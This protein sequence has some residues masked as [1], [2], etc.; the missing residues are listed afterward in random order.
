MSQP[1]LVDPRDTTGLDV[2]GLLNPTHLAHLAGLGPK[3]ALFGGWRMKDEGCDDPDCEDEDCDGDHGVEDTD[4]ETE[5]V[6]GGKTLKVGKLQRIMA[7]EKRQGKKAG[8]TA[9][10]TELGFDS[11]DDAKAFVEKNKQAKPPKKKT[12][13]NDDDEAATAAARERETA[14]EK[15][16]RLAAE[17]ER[18]AD[19]RG[20]LRDAGVS[21]DDLDDVHA[22]LDREVDAEYDED[23]LEEAV[24]ALKERRPSF[25]GQKDEDAERPRPRAKAKIPAGGGP[26]RKTSQGKTG[27]DAGKARAQRRW[28][29]TTTKD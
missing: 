2:T 14:A 18:K 15:R 20:A 10:L 4:P 22:L 16:E 19:L 26:R 23:E 21:R 12:G 28:G 8:Q 17:K 9:L 13:E 27:W 1:K 6:V 3:Y 29:T 7:T 11:L 5:I 24:E 25:F